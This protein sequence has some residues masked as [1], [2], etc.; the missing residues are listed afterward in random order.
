M[1][2]WSGLALDMDRHR[3]VA[4]VGG[5]GKTTLLYALA[6]E[7][8]DG[9]RTVLVTTTTHM[10]PH[11]RLP[12]TGW[13]GLSRLRA[14]LDRYGILFLGRPV[15]DGRLTGEGDISACL[16]AAD[17]VL[18]EADGSKGLP[19]KA[20]ADHEPVLPPQA[21]AVIAVAGADCVGRTIGAAC[22]RPERVCALLGRDP[23][24]PIT[25]EDVAAV[26][27]SPA[28]GRKGV[29]VGADFRCAVNKADLAPR[30]AEAVRD[31][32]LAL[33]IP[34][35]TTAFSPEEREGD[36]LL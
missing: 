4:L 33:G 2:L 7:A 3:A 5:G 8:R 34:T 13:E 12:L 1:S 23:E 17:L 6:R 9:G 14:M 20:P 36:R 30:A 28:G 25:P 16:R 32:L 26:L 10:R 18:I 31:R 22:H 15:Q 35:M 29:P 19:L 27:S 24:A 11:P 21:E